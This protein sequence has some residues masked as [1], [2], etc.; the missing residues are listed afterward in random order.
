MRSGR[1]VLLFALAM[2]AFA[3][4][5]SGAPPPTATPTKPPTETAPPTATPTPSP[6]PTPT[7]GPCAGAWVGEWTQVFFQTNTGGILLP[8]Y[9]V[10]GKRLIL[11]DD[12]TYTEDWS[13]EASDIGCQSSGLIEGE[14]SVSDTT[15][16]FT[17]VET[18][19]EVGLDCGGG[20]QLAGSA[21]TIPLNEIPPPGY[22]FDLAALPAELT[23]QATFTSQEGYDISVIQGFAP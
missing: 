13:E 7:P 19:T 20:A 5:C 11:R 18:V 10:V 4:A 12:C 21:A 3:S 15:I 22:S 23:L 1:I 9:T 17:P 14:Y 16:A 6:T 2:A 8:T